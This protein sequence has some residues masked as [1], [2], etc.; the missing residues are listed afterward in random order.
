MYSVVIRVSTLTV[1]YPG[2][3]AAYESDCPNSTF[4]SDGEV[5]R[6]GFMS[7]AD[8]EL[9]MQS[10]RR[11]N[12]SLENAAAAIIREDKGLL[13]PSE[14]LEFHRIDETPMGR[15]VGSALNVLVAPPG[16]VP[17]ERRVLTTEAELQGQEVLANSDGVTTYRDRATGEI[18]HVGR[19][20]TKAP[21]W[22]PWWKVWK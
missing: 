13:Q 16:W 12:I 20:L 11:F 14:W 15:L 19:A 1:H 18:V 5:C 6:V 2:G 17:G 22:K 21:S 10:L 8:T 7:W 9:F 3:V 4:C